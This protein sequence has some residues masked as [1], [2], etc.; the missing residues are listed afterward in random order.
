MQEQELKFEETRVIINL[1]GKVVAKTATVEYW[2]TS[3]EI[4]SIAGLESKHI[5]SLANILELP[6]E[7]PKF[8]QMALKISRHL[9]DVELRDMPCE[10]KSYWV[11]LYPGGYFVFLMEIFV[12]LLT[13]VRSINEYINDIVNEKKAILFNGKDTKF[14]E[15]SKVIIEDILRELRK[16]ENS[17]NIKIFETYS[18]INPRKISPS[19]FNYKDVIGTD[20]KQEY[21]LYEAAIRRMPLSGVRMDLTRSEQKN[22]SLY[23]EDMAYINYH[24]LFVYVT[25]VASRLQYAYELMMELYKIYAARLISISEDI[26]DHLGKLGDKI[27]EELGKLI[28]QSTWVETM[29][30]RQLQAYE[31]FKKSLDVSSTRLKWFKLSASE[32]LL[33]DDLYA[34]I[35]ERLGV[36]EKTISRGVT[37]KQNE[38]LQKVSVRLTILSIVVAAVGILVAI[39]VFFAGSDAMD[40]YREPVEQLS[41]GDAASS[42]F[43][44]NCLL[45]RGTIHQRQLWC[46]IGDNGKV[47]LYMQG[48]YTAL[49]SDTI[50]Q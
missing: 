46:E 1:T 42:M 29:R 41:L 20:K 16:D 8:P 30:L 19:G 25:N 17:E 37:L 39:A 27:P 14:I 15:L 45:E 3:Q 35:T 21:D 50:K 5:E 33:A 12:P 7:L 32:K 31:Q 38:S 26:S 36:F 13:D 18:I 2:P 49:V 43:L 9:N 34:K 24:N 10:I 4:V 47:P 48:H 40:Y 6:F 44:E 28:E 11:R 23:D 22:V